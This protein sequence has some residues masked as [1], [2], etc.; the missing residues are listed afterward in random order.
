MRKGVSHSREIQKGIDYKKLARIFLVLKEA[1]DW[2]H[3]AEIARRAQ[4]NQ[5]TTRWYIDHYLKN[6]VEETVIHPKIRIRLIKLKPNISFKNLTMAL[7]TLKR[8][9]SENGQK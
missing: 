4:L 2:M 7:E 1:N 5:A 3:I 9:R 8:I 6:V